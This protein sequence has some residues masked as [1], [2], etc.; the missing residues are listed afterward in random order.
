MKVKLFTRDG[1]FV[2]EAEVPPF[3]TPPDLIIWGERFFVVP[4]VDGPVGQ[5]A[6]DSPEDVDV[7]QEA[8]AYAIPPAVRS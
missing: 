1:G 3:L 4:D 5:I 6:A 8:F 7:L 2:H